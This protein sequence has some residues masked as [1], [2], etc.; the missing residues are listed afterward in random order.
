MTVFIS[1][2][3]FDIDFVDRLIY[4]LEERGFDAW[5]TH[6]DTDGGSA[7]R[8]ST[9]QAMRQCQAVIVVLSPHFAASQNAAKELSIAD[10]YKRPIIPLKTTH[11]GFSQAVDQVVQ[12]LRR[13]PPARLP[14]CA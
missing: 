9:S 4:K 12:T 3:Q 13:L 2:S 7:W 5:S 10:Q 11:S 14:A 6:P 8:V 1:H